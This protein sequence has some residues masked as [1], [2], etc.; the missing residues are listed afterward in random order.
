[1]RVFMPPRKRGASRGAVAADLCSVWNHV[2]VL[3][4]PAALES[5]PND[6]P[7]GGAALR[8]HV[9]GVVL[10]RADKEMTRIAAKRVVASVADDQALG[11]YFAV[12]EFICGSVSM[13]GAA[14]VPE[15]AVAIGADCAG[16]IPARRCGADVDALPKSIA[17]I[18]NL[19]GVSAWPR[20]V[21]TYLR[22]VVPERLS[23]A[24]ALA[25][26]F[27]RSYASSRCVVA[28]GATECAD[29]ARSAHLSRSAD[30][31]DVLDLLRVVLAQSLVSFRESHRL[32]IQ[33][34]MPCAFC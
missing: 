13:S 10:R 25:L 23:A 12:G 14:L 11:C 3:A 18:L 24:L 28:G 33:Q 30:D 21:A 17:N 8:D 20:T 34:V 6:V 4:A 32:I 1:M 16:P 19:R 15:L 27:F 5:D 26:D 7:S 31:A 2:E 9:G 29:L 22:F